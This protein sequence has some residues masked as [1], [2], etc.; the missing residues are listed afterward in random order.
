M[1]GIDT[2]VSDS[3]ITAVDTSNAQERNLGVTETV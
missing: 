1:S 2:V 3:A